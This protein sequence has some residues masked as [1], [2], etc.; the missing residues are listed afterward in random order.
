MFL[1]GTVDRTNINGRPVEI[2]MYTAKEQGSFGQ[3]FRWLSWY[4]KDI[5]VT[6]SDPSTIR[7][8]R[9]FFFIIFSLCVHV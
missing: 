2:F 1:L 9:F 6:D 8:F 5:Y 4:L 3:A 7:L